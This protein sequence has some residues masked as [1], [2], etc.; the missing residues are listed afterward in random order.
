[1]FRVPSKS[2]S[3]VAHSFL[4]LQAE[5][6]EKNFFFVTCIASSII[7]IQI[8]IESWWVL[9]TLLN[10]L[11][12][13][14]V[15]EWISMPSHQRKLVVLTYYIMF[16]PFYRFVV[17]QCTCG[18]CKQWFSSIICIFR[19]EIESISLHSGRYHWSDLSLPTNTYVEH[20]LLSLF[21]CC[22]SRKY[23]FGH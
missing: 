18:L 8:A 12:V 13:Q 14:W 22:L 4:S 6:S 16:L 21:W 23:I 11:T 2:P 9:S 10:W 5:K 3:A 15:F 20:S 7:L 19:R 1:M 17:V